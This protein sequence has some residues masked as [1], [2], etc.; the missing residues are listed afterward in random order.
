MAQPTNPA[1][2]FMGPFTGLNTR[3]APSDLG[4]GEAQVAENVMLRGGRVVPHPPFE[5]YGDVNLGVRP[6]YIKG[7]IISMAHIHTASLSRAVHRGWPSGLVILI[8]YQHQRGYNKFAMVT[9]DQVLD[10]Y[11]PSLAS[12]WRAQFLLANKMVY[13]LDGSSPYMF[14]TDCTQQGWYPIGLH[15][16]T[17]STPT[18]PSAE[19]DFS[20][21]IVPFYAHAVGEGY[22]EYGITWYDPVHNVE[23]NP[24]IYATQLAADDSVV[25]RKRNPAPPS[26]AHIR[27]RVYRRL[28]TAGEEGIGFL[29]HTGVTA[30]ANAPSA[31]FVDRVDDPTSLEAMGTEQDGPYVPSRNGVPPPSRLACWY[32]NRMFYVDYEDG[33]KLWFSEDG[34]PDHVADDNY[35]IVGGDPEDQITGLIEHS[36]QLVII[37]LHSIHI[38]SGAIS[39]H[40]N[41][42][43][44]RGEVPFIALPAQYRTHAK[45]GCHNRFGN[46]GAV[47][48]G[49]PPAVHYSHAA[50]LYQFEGLHDVPLADQIRPTW[51][52]RYIEYAENVPGHWV[53][54]AVDADNHNLYVLLASTYEEQKPT[55]LLVY[56]WE[57]RGW[58]TLKI[59]EAGAICDGST[60]WITAICSAIGRPRHRAAGGGNYVD[61]P[62]ES[63]PLLV[64][65]YYRNTEMSAIWFAHEQ[66]DDVDE[67]LV[68]T[69]K[70]HTG[71]LPVGG[72]ADAQV[73]HLRYFHGDRESAVY[74]EQKGAVLLSVDG[75]AESYVQVG[76]GA[77][78]LQGWLSL[79]GVLH[80]LSVNRFGRS[81]SFRFEGYAASP[82]YYRRSHTPG[83]SGFQIDSE[84][85]DVR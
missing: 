75:G 78:G 38:V 72:G 10:G 62:G 21:E 84:V 42:T 2:S 40:T 43:V 8:K 79:D 36:G 71:D 83:L 19:A 68:P 44:A 49:S 9:R 11:L 18:T 69:W 32:K 52:N 67:L 31:T 16:P 63:C 70:W 51:E 80:T 66:A 27:F 57:R 45:T 26:R 77:G 12:E 50:G 34:T 6:D 76:D 54:Y 53:N 60:S 35:L 15:P 20:F 1:I 59:S 24:F 47:I 30:D 85:A 17:V 7:R 5:T 58:T 56:N 81:M 48:C 33:S 3:D 29:V 37:K 39:F 25:I 65:V 14:K 55:E 73:Y 82:G 64:A 22:W 41:E 4:L 74:G 13:I 28:A 46:N 61:H 23:S